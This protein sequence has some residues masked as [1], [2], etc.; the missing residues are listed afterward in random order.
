MRRLAWLL[1]PMV[2]GSLLAAAPAFAAGAETCPAP[3]VTQYTA[4]AVGGQATYPAGAG[5]SVV[6]KRASATAL[7]VVKVAPATGWTDIVNAAT[8]TVLRVRLTGPESGVAHAIHF[9]A[10]L[11]ATGTMLLTRITDCTT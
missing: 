8:G 9:H 10:H 3:T 5:G 4:P 11:N 7:K 2:L 1:A 6:I